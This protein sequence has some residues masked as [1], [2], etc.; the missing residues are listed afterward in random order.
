VSCG[1]A[2][3]LQNFRLPL[4]PRTMIQRICGK[5]IRL[6]VVLFTGLAGLGAAPAAQYA[7][8]SRDKAFVREGPSY[9][10]HVLWIYRRKNLPVEIV[11]SYDVWRKIRD[12]DGT[13]GWV[14]SSM[15]SDRRTV[16]IR[17]HSTAKIT[18]KPGGK[19]LALAQPGV[20]ARLEACEVDACEV[21]ADGTEGWIKKQDIWGV[22]AGEVFQ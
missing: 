12:E 11:Q 14:H 20:V 7:S 10:S 8:L 1:L 22:D 6:A 15:L 17:S 21:S 4:E 5:T 9:Q 19:V 13:T 2:V 18:D 3:T 16:V